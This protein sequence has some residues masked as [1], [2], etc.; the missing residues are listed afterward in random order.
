MTDRR[1]DGLLDTFIGE[2]CFVT[3]RIAPHSKGAVRI[4]GND[5]PAISDSEIRVGQWV[6]ITDHNGSE[7][8]AL[9]LNAWISTIR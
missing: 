5:I 4:W 6:R 8:N 1:D 3:S 9:P 2:V 7:L